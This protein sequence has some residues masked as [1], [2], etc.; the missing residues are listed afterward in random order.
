MVQSLENTAANLDSTVAEN[1]TS[2]NQVM[3]NVASLSTSLE[4]T[5]GD[6][7]NAIQNF[8]TLSDTLSRIEFAQTMAKANQ[9]LEDVGAITRKIASG[10]GTLGKL[11]VSDSLHDGLV[12]TT[13]SQFVGRPANAPLEIRAGQLSVE[14]RSLSSQEG[15]TPP[16]HH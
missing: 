12:A 2:F 7:T 13:S 16:C 11:L 6:L 9:A 15:L 4:S 1:R 5:S 8:S 3:S 10:E 14:N